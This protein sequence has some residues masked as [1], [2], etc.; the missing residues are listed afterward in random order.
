MDAIEEFL[1]GS[2]ANLGAERILATVA[3]TDIVGSTELAAEL[4]DLRWRELLE[5]HDSVAR[6]EVDRARGH[7]VKTT[8]DGML[9]TFDGPARAI[10]ALV[11]MSDYL[12]P[13]GLP[14]RGGLHAGEVEVRDGDIGGI[15]VHIASRVSGMAGSGEVLVSSTVKDLVAG[16]GIGFEDRGVHELKGVPTKWQLYAVSAA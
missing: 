10:R 9:A 16:S 1:T 5:T 3:F 14:I 4:G 15:A 11:A 6:R 2:R 7:I 8:G 12:L 13:V